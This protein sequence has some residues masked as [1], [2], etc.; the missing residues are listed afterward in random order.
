MIPKSLIYFLIISLSFT[1]F[2]TFSKDEGVK[3]III[4]YNDRPPYMF[5]EN[6]KIK[7]LTANPV[8]IIFDKAGIPHRWVKT[9]SKKQ[10]VL[11]EK[12]LGRNCLIGWFK[13]PVREKFAKY[14][15]HIY[16]DK[17]QIAITRVDNEKIKDQ[18]TVDEIL[19]NPNLVLLTK[20][21]YSYGQ[22]LDKKIEEH[23]PKRLEIVEDSA[24]ML[25][26]LYMKRSDYFFI[27][28]EEAEGLIKAAGYP[29]EDFRFISFLDMPAGE[30]RYILLSQ[31]VEDYIIDELN[32]VIEETI[33]K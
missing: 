1:P 14:T 8:N 2:N 7:G 33:H 32:R 11:L 31:Q 3:E 16:Q 19:V 17:P 20:E 13:N 25:K 18:I 15:H 21:G 4:H 29:R 9:S 6:G 26:L 5:K 27:A 12:D 24:V 28:P 22:Y 10:M 23:E 30:K